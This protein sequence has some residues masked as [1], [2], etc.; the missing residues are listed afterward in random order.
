MKAMIVDDEGS[1]RKMLKDYLINL[2]VDE[3]LECK[4]GLEALNTIE[5]LAG[6]RLSAIFLDLN[7]DG[8]DGLSF[9]QEYI[10]KSIY[11]DIPIFVITG[12]P[13]ND[14]IKTCFRHEIYCF[15]EKPFKF[16]QIRDCISIARR[17]ETADNILAE[18]L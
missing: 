17:I 15:V 4:N 13:S 2:D 3:I 8:M 16:N 9:L 12:D 18:T 1:I 14:K 5:G 10:E 6:E 7:M 11:R